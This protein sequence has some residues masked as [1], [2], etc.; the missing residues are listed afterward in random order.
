MHSS[1]F[2]TNG[3]VTTNLETPPFEKK[4]KNIEVNHHALY[5]E[6]LEWFDFDQEECTGMVFKAKQMNVNETRNKA[7]R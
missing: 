2:F 6:A 3:I 4:V 1:G 7:I 5:V